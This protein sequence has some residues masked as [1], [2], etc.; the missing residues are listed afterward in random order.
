MKKRLGKREKAKLFS[1]L[2]AHSHQFF[3][4]FP[5]FVFHS[6][7]ILKSTFHSQCEMAP[8]GILQFTTIPLFGIYHPWVFGMSNP[9]SFLLCLCSLLSLFHGIFSSPPFLCAHTL[10]LGLPFLSL[11]LGRSQTAA[12]GHVLLISQNLKKH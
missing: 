3:F 7:Q 11:L 6:C 8:C 9:D 12:H 10:I 2:L 5:Y 4:N 1:F